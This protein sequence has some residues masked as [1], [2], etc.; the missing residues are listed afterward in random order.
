MKNIINPFKLPLVK[1]VTK[2]DINNLKKWDSIR[3]SVGNS[4][5]D[6]VW[7]SVESSVK[8][9]MKDSI[10][11]SINENICDSVWE[12]VDENIWDS[13]RR[14]VW[15]SVRDSVCAY[16]GYM[17][18][19]KRSEWKYTTKI[20]TKDY[21]FLPLIKLWARGLMPS[22]DGEIWRLHSGKNAKIIFEIS[23]DELK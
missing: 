22:F 6:S 9:S 23:K 12:S 20:K 3:D 15:D 1:Q 21:P 18:K 13:V 16:I 17:F 10:W 14:S 11:D 4:V 5:K 7:D 8:Y 19:L 2:T